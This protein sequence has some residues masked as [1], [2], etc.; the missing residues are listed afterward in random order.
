MFNMTPK[1]KKKLPEKSKILLT[2]ITAEDLSQAGI[3]PSSISSPDESD[4][5]ALV[6]SLSNSSLD[7]LK[8]VK[9]ISLK[10]SVPG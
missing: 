1:K 2:I 4:A 5:L 9:D 3:T 10:D 8:T 6:K 7:T